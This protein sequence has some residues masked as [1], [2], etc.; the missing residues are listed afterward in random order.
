M[1]GQTERDFPLGHPA[2]V[3]TVPGSPE[4]LAW[5]RLHDSSRGER[6]FPPGHPKAADTPGNSNHIAW[7]AGVDPMNA[8]LE[9]FTGRTEE[10]A[11]AAAEYARQA[12]ADAP[13][14]IALEPIDS[15]AANKAL[16][17]ERK[18]LKVDALTAEQHAKVLAEL[19][20][21]RADKE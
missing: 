15:L 20:A 10:Q 1:A 17:A 21:A 8:H 3:D 13:E 2:A 9:P 14:S 11:A 5:L 4:H 12:A 7:A 16:A 18:R 19:Q 6:D